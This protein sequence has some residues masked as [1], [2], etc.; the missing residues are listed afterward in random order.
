MLKVCRT[1]Q[2]PSQTPVVL[3]RRHPPKGVV[4]Q[5][6]CFQARQRIETPIALPIHGDLI[7]REMQLPEL[8][9]LFDACRNGSE[10]IVT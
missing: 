9:Q 10:L 5:I 6:E 7:V 8:S 1:Q 4:A 2:Q 3:Q